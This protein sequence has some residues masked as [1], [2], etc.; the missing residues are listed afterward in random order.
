MPA[1]D[2]LTELLVEAALSAAKEGEWRRLTVTQLAERA[3][4]GPDAAEALFSSADDILDAFAQQTDERV[5]SALD[6]EEFAEASPKERLLEALMC[7]LD[8]L[9]PHRSA[10]R[11]FGLEAQRCP[12][13]GVRMFRRIHTSMGNVLDAADLAGSEFERTLRATALTY[14]WIRTSRRWLLEEED[15]GLDAIFAMLDQELGRLETLARCMQG[16][17]PRNPGSTPS[18]DQPDAQV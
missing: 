4:V 9:A 18:A 6:A 1:T 2:S 11:A 17:A 14:V 12:N 10:V 5:V 13:A 16:F 8:V 7:R 15:R 3:N